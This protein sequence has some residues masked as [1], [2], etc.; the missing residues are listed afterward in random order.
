MLD[1]IKWIAFAAAVTLST[2]GFAGDF[3]QKPIVLVIPFSA[4]GTHDVH[5]R[6]VA[7]TIKDYLPQPMVIKL[8]PGAGGQKGATSVVDAD[9]DGYT[10]LFGHNLI[11]QLHPHVQDLPYDPLK[12]LRVIWKLNDTLAVLYVRADSPFQDLSQLI[13]YGRTHPGELVFANSGLWGFSFTVG[14]ILMSATGIDLNMV[15]YKGGGPARAAMLAG[16]GDVSSTPY[17]SIQSLHE[18]GKVRVLAVIGPDRLAALPDVPS[19]ADLGLPYEGAI[20]ERIV[21]APADTPADRIA[22]LRDAF[23]KLYANKEF[24]RLIKQMGENLNFMDGAQY[25]S[26]RRRQ[27][28]EYRAL[29]E[30][31]R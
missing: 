16:D 28:R 18:A 8:V 21:L 14:A 3:P 29:T 10:L 25:E 17:S 2:A 9:P 19:F 26:V 24:V 13:N 1:R 20:M 7:K 11:D 31:L 6:I 5:A 4:G 30:R 15:S 12:A 27:T 23:A 22:V